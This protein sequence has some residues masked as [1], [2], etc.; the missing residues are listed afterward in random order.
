MPSR[1]VLDRGV[2]PAPIL[3]ALL[4]AVAALELLA[5]F[6][7][8]QAVQTA[9]WAAMILVVAFALR[10]LTLREVYLLSASAVLT[11]LVL[12]TQPDPP[13]ILAGALN[14][15]AFLMTF[16]LLLGLLQATAATS[17]SVAIMGEYLTRQPP[18][19]RYVALN[20]GT[21]LLAVLFN[22][23][24]VSFL[25]PLIQQGI[26]RA[27]PGD[28][29]NPIRE[30]R[31]IS[32]LLRGFAWSV[33]WSPTAFAPLIVAELMPGVERSAWIGYG[34]ALF[35]A[36][37]A[38]GWLEDRIRFRAYKPKGLRQPMPFP[39]TA[40][41][42]FAATT[43]WFLALV[44][45]FVWAFGESAVFGVLAACPVMVIGW[46]IAQGGTT[47]L[48]ARLRRIA[49]T[50]L[51]GSVNVAITLACSGYIGRAAAGL[52]PAAEVAEA[53]GLAGMPD[54][55]LLASIPSFLTLISL[56]ALSPT[57]MAVFMGSFFAALPEMPADATLLAFSISCGWAVSMTFSPFATVVLVIARA[58]GLPARRLT[59]GWNLQFT[60][61]S[62]L[63]MYPVFYLLTGG[64]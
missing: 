19:R 48:P 34:L 3:A 44:V 32:A 42:R 24:V 7:G 63:L 16:I 35:A 25:V 62:A 33:T 40:A 21:S 10:R 6:S 1:T 57:M 64:Q 43:C 11:V 53:L 60:L 15:A 55:L 13:G 28:A 26:R 45:A 4:I 52:T 9:A 41:A 22:I 61:M 29:L 39:R 50:E 5:R 56:L 20:G 58:S 18:G 17:P 46:L 49:G 37:M 36:L 51:P 59:W 31:Q 38:L 12:L 27:A 23:G 14:Q 2:R 30:Q 8:L 54:W 47:A